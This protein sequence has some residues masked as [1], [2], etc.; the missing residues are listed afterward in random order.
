[1]LVSHL[2][3]HHR[4]AKLGEVTGCA[5]EGE[6]VLWHYRGRLLALKGCG[7]Y[8]RKSVLDKRDTKRSHSCVCDP[9]RYEHAQK[10][11]AKLSQ[12]KYALTRD[13]PTMVALIMAPAALQLLKRMRPVS[14]NALFLA[15]INDRHG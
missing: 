7:R 14:T 8:C 3:Q 5:T 4:S 15:E 13:E 1:M 2:H 10:A 6:G 12:T 9:V 11:M